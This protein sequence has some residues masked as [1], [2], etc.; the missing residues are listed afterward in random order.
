MW[1][2][3]HRITKVQRVGVGL[4]GLLF[5]LSGVSIGSTM[6]GFWPAYL[7]AGGFLGVGGKL[8][9]EQRS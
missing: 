4:F 1:K 5:L 2:G 6:D 3:S 8:P 9:L 7:I